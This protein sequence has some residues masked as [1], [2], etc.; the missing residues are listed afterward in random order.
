MCA[1]A[2]RATREETVERLFADYL[3]YGRAHV[4]ERTIESYESLARLYVLPAIGSL[5]VAKVATRDIARLHL[6]LED[7]PGTANRGVQMVKAFFYWLERGGLFSGTNPARN[8]ELYAEHPRERFLT[9]EEMARVGQALCV[10]ETIGLPPAPE[11]KLTKSVKRARNSGM[12][13]SELQPASPVTLAA[14]RFLIFTGWREQ[15]AMTLKWSDVNLSAGIATLGDTKSGKN[16]R[17]ITA[18]AL[19]LLGAQAR[20]KG[21]AY[22]FPGRDPQK[23][24]ESVHRLWTAVRSEARL[25]GVRLHDLRHSVASFA[26][27]QGYSLFLIGKLLGHKTAR[28]TERYAHL[29]DDA[30]KI[31]ADDVGET[32]RAAMAADPYI[33]TAPVVDIAT[34]RR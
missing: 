8:V 26:G 20:V 28:S 30:R 33:H 3:D 32:I 7:K 1:D 14:L 31:M 23:P 6:S 21:S 24:L 2:R 34:R 17:A 10:A 15:E 29:A 9:V 4:K 19:E 22:V 11:H 27:G 5:P 12:F 18:P 16:V 25:E 13:K